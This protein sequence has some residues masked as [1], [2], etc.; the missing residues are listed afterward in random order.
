LETASRPARAIEMGSAERQRQRRVRGVS[1]AGLREIGNGIDLYRDRERLGRDA[2]LRR[3]PRSTHNNASRTAQRAVP[4]K[5]KRRQG[6]FTV[7]AGHVV[8]GGNFEIRP[9]NLLP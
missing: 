7:E 2:A 4:T 1:R 5:R 6:I 8:Y 3:P 9:W